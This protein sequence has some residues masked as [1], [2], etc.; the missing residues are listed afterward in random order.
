MIYLDC[1]SVSDS[2]VIPGI[3]P[4]DYECIIP[5]G[6]EKLVYRGGISAYPVVDRSRTTLKGLAPLSVSFVVGAAEGVESDCAGAI[7][8]LNAREW[9]PATDDTSRIVL[10]SPGLSGNMLLFVNADTG[11]AFVSSKDSG[12]M[13]SVDREGTPV[14]KR[15]S[16][17]AVMRSLL[18]RGNAVNPTV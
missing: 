2:G 3:R 15:L 8:S 17:A 11:H 18:K 4:D 7:I 1:Y 6:D 5:E 14:L 9:T 12:L 16:R 13:L 10:I